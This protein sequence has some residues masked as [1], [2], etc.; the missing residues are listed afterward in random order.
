M[1]YAAIKW[2]DIA[3]GPGI[4]ISLFV[5]GCTLHCSECFNKIAWDFNYGSLFTKEVQELIFEKM[6]KNKVYQGI[7]ILGGEPLDPRNQKGLLPFLI[8]FRKRFTDKN[9]WMFS[10]YS[11]EKIPGDKTILKYVD[12]LVDGP[13]QIQNK[14]LSLPFK[15]S[16]NQRT[17]DV[18][19]TLKEK[20]II[21]MEGY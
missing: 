5:S 10:G 7:S 8:E 4:R 9:V 21:L 2:L 14:N 20:K 19:K 17:I 3:N 1:N 16:S 15:G 18:Q 11:W 12:V 6:E 13:F